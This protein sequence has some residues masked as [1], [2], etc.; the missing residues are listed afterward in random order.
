MD[1]SCS[2]SLS[3]LSG[4]VILSINGK[5]MEDVHHKDLV[6]FIKHAGQTMR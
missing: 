6:A 3:F 4:D 1:E 2:G 5:S